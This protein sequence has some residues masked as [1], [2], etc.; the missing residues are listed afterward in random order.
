MT[1]VARHATG[2]CHPI[3]CVSLLHEQ[4]EAF[5]ITFFSPFWAGIDPALVDQNIDRVEP[6]NFSL[7][8]VVMSLHELIQFVDSDTFR[9]LTHQA[10][11]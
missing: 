11:N 4:L 8:F 5:E 9:M 3:L 2:F 1:G 6:G 10:E 7:E